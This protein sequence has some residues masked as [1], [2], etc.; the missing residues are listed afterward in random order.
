MHLDYNDPIAWLDHRYPC[1]VQARNASIEKKF[2]SFFKP[3][4][5][6]LH[7]TDVGA[8]TATNVCYYF[9]KFKHQQE[10]T[11]IERHDFLLQAAR[12]RLKKFAERRGYL[13]DEQS[14]QAQLI[15]NDKRAIIRFVT[16]DVHFLEELTDMEQTDVL[17]ANAFYDLVS[18]DQFDALIKK[19]AQS[20]IAFLSTLNYYETS[21]YPFQEEDHQ[22]IRWYH[23]HMKRPQPFGIAMGADCCEEML[24]ILTQHHLMIEQ[25]S[26]QWRLKRSDT[27][28]QHYILHFIENALGELNLTSEEQN[29]FSQWLSIRKKQLHNRS[30]EIIVDHNDIFATE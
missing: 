18:F 6:V 10:W 21:F 11:L 24:D 17:V 29:L 27:T 12:K 14:D 1:D 9:D 15:D 25:E 13:W 20:N 16:G 5:S 23:M 22:I 2:F 7:I 19:I 30:L 28:M 3:H 8:G 4:A 26:S